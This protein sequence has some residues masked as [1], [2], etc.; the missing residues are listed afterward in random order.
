MERRGFLPHIT[1]A[2]FRQRPPGAELKRYLAAN[3]GFRTAPSDIECFHLFSSELH[4]TGARYTI[5]KTF[6][7]TP[8]AR[9]NTGPDRLNKV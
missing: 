4:P 6:P 3:A 5:E 8:V 7:L 9:E 2:R 1:I